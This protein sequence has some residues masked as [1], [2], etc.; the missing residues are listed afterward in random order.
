M[1]YNIYLI[2]GHMMGSCLSINVNIETRRSSKSKMSA[3]YPKTEN[4]FQP[5]TAAML[6][7][8]KEDVRTKLSVYTKEEILAMN[9]IWMYTQPKH[10]RRALQKYLLLGINEVGSPDGPWGIMFYPSGYV[11]LNEKEKL[12]ARKRTG[13]FILSG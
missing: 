7:D 10:E 9:I 8:H 6:F 12:G 13:S 4:I 1:T 11:E 5:D 3:N 2:R